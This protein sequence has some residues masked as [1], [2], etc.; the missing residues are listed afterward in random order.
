MSKYLLETTTCSRLMVDDPLVETRL[1]SAQINDE[2]FT[3]PIV[4]GEIRYVLRDYLSG[5]ETQRYRSLGFDT[6]PRLLNRR[7]LT[8][9][10]VLLPT[11]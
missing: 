5:K 6:E 9:K 3:C 1:A 4:K 11:D 2:V 8:E 10:V 7:S